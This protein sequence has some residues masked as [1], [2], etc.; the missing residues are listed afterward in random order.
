LGTELGNSLGTELE[1]PSVPPL[2][3]NSLGTELKIEQALKI[4]PKNR[5][6]SNSLIKNPASTKAFSSPAL[7]TSVCA[8]IEN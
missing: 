5:E 3:G 8:K 7:Y 4:E 6:F 1:T 2:L